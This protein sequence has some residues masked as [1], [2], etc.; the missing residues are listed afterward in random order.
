MLLFY[1]KAYIDFSFPFG[2][3][4]IHRFKK[5]TLWVIV[6]LKQFRCLGYI[7]VEREYVGL[8]ITATEGSRLSATYRRGRF[9]LIEASHNNIM[10][11]SVNILA[12][13]STVKT[14]VNS[15]DIADLT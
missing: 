3:P 7:H 15:L 2:K 13:Q 5:D 11:S 9:K 14:Q 4:L 10:S 1:L 6:F 8:K 12:L